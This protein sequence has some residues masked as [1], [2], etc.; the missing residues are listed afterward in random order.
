M[1]L[2]CQ[3]R[4]TR[5]IFDRAAIGTLLLVNFAAF[6]GCKHGNQH[7]RWPNGNSQYDR[8]IVARGST[9]SPDPP[10]APVCDPTAAQ[11][12]HWASK[13]D[14]LHDA[15]CVDYY[16]AAVRLSWADV[17]ALGPQPTFRNRAAAFFFA[18]PD[19]PRRIRICFCSSCRS[20][21]IQ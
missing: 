5:G 19:N 2:P 6:G 18:A 13:L 14:A 21:D 9:S 12:A 20:T 4:R 15:T 3:E 10:P 17:A 11:L 7:A 8:L 1:S 16:F